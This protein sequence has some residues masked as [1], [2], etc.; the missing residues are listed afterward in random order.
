MV[1]LSEV[2]NKTTVFTSITLN[3]LPKARVLASTLSEC[4]PEWYFILS[5]YDVVPNEV[6]IDWSSEPF[7]MLITPLDLEVEDLND[8]TFS[9]TVVE[10]CTAVKGILAKQILSA[11]AKNVIYFDPDMA[12]FNRMDNLVSILEKHPCVLAPHQLE[13]E[14]EYAAIV[15]NEIC[16]LKHGVFNLGFFAANNSDEGMRFITWWSN[17]LLK[18]CF[19]DIAKGLF[20]DQKWCDLAPCFFPE[21]YI[22]RDPGCDV[23]SWNLS[24]REISIGSDGVLLVN[25]SPLK[26]FHFTS[27]DSGVGEIMTDRYAPENV[28]VK[29]IWNWYRR[30]LLE[31]GQRELG[32]I[33]WYYN[34]FADGTTIDPSHRSEFR[35]TGMPP[36]KELRIVI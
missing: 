35:E 21:M 18:F 26:F 29:E 9:H 22:W 32:Q 4:H 25:E 3:Y 27:V 7:D 34:T 24:R 16:S 8:F 15:D 1:D 23:A 20:T 36:N 33:P 11:G 6:E 31:A 14:E 5:L 28:V 10:A 17:R 13:P 30:T 19:D 12:V 2:K